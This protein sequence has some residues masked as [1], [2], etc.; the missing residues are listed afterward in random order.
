MK[1]AERGTVLV[2]TA[3]LAVGLVGCPDKSDGV[4]QAI[5]VEAQGTLY[6][7]GNGGVT[8]TPGA[9][10]LD[11][12][13]QFEERQPVIG[14]DDDSDLDLTAVPPAGCRVQTF[15]P[16]AGD[17]PAA[18]VNAGL[19]SATV[20]GGGVVGLAPS[21]PMAIASPTP[22]PSA[23]AI[24]GCALQDVAGISAYAC[25]FGAADSGM[26]A[27]PWSGVPTAAALFPILSDS[28]TAGAC[29]TSAY[30]HTNT[31]CVP[32]LLGATLDVSVAGAA[33]PYQALTPAAKIPIAVPGGLTITGI[34]LGGTDLALLPEGAL[35]ALDGHFTTDG[36]LSIRFSC[37][38]G[39]IE[40]GA[41][42]LGLVGLFAQT[43]AAKR[44]GTPGATS[45]FAIAEC[46]AAA[47]ATGTLTMKAAQVQKLRAA[48]A[49]GSVRITVAR[50]NGQLDRAA[51]AQPVLRGAGRGEFVYVDQ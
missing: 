3:T 38:A 8:T 47:R 32:E 1:N 40:K 19:V 27:S 13:V 22:L 18:Q 2:A 34:T 25:A 35:E 26:A 50:F 51:D 12:V 21:G 37:G 6:M 10:V 44:G 48:A 24:I 5:V 36:V 29:P 16:T 11:T 17:L 33:G 43:S 20:V 46:V 31:F 9:H 39:C 7:A 41:A 15:S 45:R 4:G 14:D 30:R 23:G 42:D 49:G 28:L